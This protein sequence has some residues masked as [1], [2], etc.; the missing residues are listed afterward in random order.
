MTSASAQSDPRLKGIFEFAAFIN[1]D[2]KPDKMLYLAQHLLRTLGNSPTASA[3][4]NE[5][6]LREVLWT[7]FADVF[8]WQMDIAEKN[9]IPDAEI[10]CFGVKATVLDNGTTIKILWR[11]IFVE[12]KK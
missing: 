9:F 5:T 11:R 2:V 4:Q 8:V 7:L 10:G 1:R 6:Q 3:V 12:S